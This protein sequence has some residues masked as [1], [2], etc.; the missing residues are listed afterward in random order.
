MQQ[1]FSGGGAIWFLSV[2]PIPVDTQFPGMEV[3]GLVQVSPAS[4]MGLTV[5]SLRPHLGGCGEK[6]G[7]PPVSPP[8]TRCPKPLCSSC[9]DCAVGVNE[10]VCLTPLISMPRTWLG[11]KLSLCTSQQLGSVSLCHPICSPWL[12]GA[13]RLCPIPQHSREGIT[14]SYCGLHL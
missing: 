5:Q 3:Q 2:Y 14:C 12:V 9:P 11:F 13:G 8:Q 1:R 4:A 7:N 10:A 6:N